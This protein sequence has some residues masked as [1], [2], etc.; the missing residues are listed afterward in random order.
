MDLVVVEA[1]LASL[2]VVCY[3]AAVRIQTRPRIV[4]MVFPTEMIGRH[5]A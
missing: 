1:A 4:T 5:R 2:A 3:A